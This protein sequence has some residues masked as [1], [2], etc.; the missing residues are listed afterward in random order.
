[1]RIYFRR[2]G[3][4]FTSAMA[5]TVLLVA[6]ALSPVAQA[7]GI[8]TPPLC[9]CAAKEEIVEPISGL[10]EIITL[11]NGQCDDLLLPDTVT[12]P[13]TGV[14]SCQPTG[15][16]FVETGESCASESTKSGCDDIGG[17]FIPPLAGE[18]CGSC[19]GPG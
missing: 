3:I 6:L 12:I 10:P 4:H 17:D 11:P 16:S 7:I 8:I 15:W 14:F 2:A 19:L 1:M 13:C 9:T 5:R 18:C